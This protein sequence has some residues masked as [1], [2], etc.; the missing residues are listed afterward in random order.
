MKTTQVRR[1]P[2]EAITVIFQSLWFA[3][4]C[5]DAGIPVTRRQA[6]KYRNGYGAAFNAR[7]K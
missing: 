3:K 4:C 2:L 7:K 5:A 1:A 6:S